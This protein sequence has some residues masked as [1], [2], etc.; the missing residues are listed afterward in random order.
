[1]KAVESEILTSLG[2]IVKILSN[3][4]YSLL[5]LADYFLYNWT[6]SDKLKIVV[7]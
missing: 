3:V 4:C 7:W 2:G 1:M 6:L 5:L